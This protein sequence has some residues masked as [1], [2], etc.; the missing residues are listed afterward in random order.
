MPFDT[1][2]IDMDFV[3]TLADLAERNDSL[4]Q[5]LYPLYD[6]KRG[7]RDADGKG[8]LVGLTR[9]GSVIGYDIVDGK[10]TPVPGRLI[11]RGYNVED[12]I[13][14]AEGHDDF[15]FEQTVYLLLCG[16]LPTSQQLSDFI[17]MMGSCRQLP[18]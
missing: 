8:V 15:G 1:T 9:V 2:D 10:K 11:Y 13:A 6:V 5:S 16:E 14:D 7:L 3:H 17:A 12:L 18:A 4:D